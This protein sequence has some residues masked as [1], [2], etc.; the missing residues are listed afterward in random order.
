[1]CNPSVE[2]LGAQLLAA[3]ICVKAMLRKGWFHILN[4]THFNTIFLEHVCSAYA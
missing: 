3:C 2:W 4:S 1:M